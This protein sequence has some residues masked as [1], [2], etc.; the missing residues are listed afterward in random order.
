MAG[1]NSTVDGMGFEEV[2]QL[3]DGRSSGTN[4]VYGFHI[5]GLTIV[6]I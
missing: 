1:L 4:I 5:S 2:N 6:Y 3:P